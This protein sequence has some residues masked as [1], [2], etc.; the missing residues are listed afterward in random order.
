MAGAKTEW[1][2]T[3]PHRGREA[4]ERATNSEKQEALRRATDFIDML[5]FKGKRATDDQKLSWPRT[6]VF[7]DDGAPVLGVPEEIKEAASLVASF[8]LAEVPFDVPAVG[9]VML[10][11]GHLLQDDIDL[12]DCAVGWH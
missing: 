9:W 8:L 3:L 6:G 2:D 11:I 1:D 5:P 10:K 7:R 4:W 12:I